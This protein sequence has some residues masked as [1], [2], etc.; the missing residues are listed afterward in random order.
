MNIAVMDNG[1]G[2]DETTNRNDDFISK[3]VGDA[4][5]YGK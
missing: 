2:Y 4:F 5:G 3:D 1:D